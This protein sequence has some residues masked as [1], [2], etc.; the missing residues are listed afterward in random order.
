MTTFERLLEVS[1]VGKIHEKVHSNGMIVK[2]VHPSIEKYISTIQNVD[3]ETVSSNAQELELAISIYSI[4][5]LDPSS[6]YYSDS[7]KY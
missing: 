5:L 4:S 6:K 7:Y 2:Y 1:T 3:D